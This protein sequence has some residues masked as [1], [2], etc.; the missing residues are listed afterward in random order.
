[1]Y[2]HSASGRSFVKLFVIGRWSSVGGWWLVVDN[3][4]S[5]PPT[6]PPPHLPTCQQMG[7]HTL[8]DNPLIMEYPSVANKNFLL[9]YALV[10]TNTLPSLPLPIRKSLSK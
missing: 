9:T 6:S 7:C 1:M 5:T 8:L 10:K 2:N 3:N 4:F